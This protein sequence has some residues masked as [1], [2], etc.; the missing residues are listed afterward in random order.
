M[1]A[2]EAAVEEDAIRDLNG[3]AGHEVDDARRQAGLLEQFEDEIVREDRGRRRLPDD[4]VPH[5][6]GSCREDAAD[7]SE[8]ERGDRVYEPRERAG[9][10]VVLGAGRRTRLLRVQRVRTVQLAGGDVAP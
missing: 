10:A 7:R 2:R 8:V 4:G 1:D 3:G 9:L 6:R 5:D